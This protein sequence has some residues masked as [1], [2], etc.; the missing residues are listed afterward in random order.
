MLELG[1][2]FAFI[3]NQYHIEVGGDEFFI[4]LLL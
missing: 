2:D 3:G 1:G 4:D